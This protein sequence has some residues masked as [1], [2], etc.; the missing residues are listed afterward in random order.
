MS[1]KVQISTKPGFSLGKELGKNLKKRMQSQIL[2]KQTCLGKI[3][4]EPK[5]ITSC[6]AQTMGVKI[7]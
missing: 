1:V 6:F 3:E 5:A 2:F 4:Q 7:G